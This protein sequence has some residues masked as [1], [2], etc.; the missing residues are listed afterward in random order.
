LIESLVEKLG[1]QASHSQAKVKREE[2]EGTCGSQ[3]RKTR[4]GCVR[5][6]GPSEEEGSEKTE[7]SLGIAD[8]REGGRMRAEWLERDREGKEEMRHLLDNWTTMTA[9][10]FIALKEKLGV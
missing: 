9:R 7:E 4:R 5:K 3:S 8:W 2:I 6:R 1:S 10:D